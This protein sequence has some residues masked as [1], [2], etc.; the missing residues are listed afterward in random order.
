MG[1]SKPVRRKYTKNYRRT[2]RVGKVSLSFVT[3][4]LF[5][6]TTILFLFQSNKIAVKGYE[7]SELEKK[8]TELS[9][10]NEKLI[11]E[12]AKLQSVNIAQESINKLKMVPVNQINYVKE[13]TGVA[14][15]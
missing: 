4:L 12:S 15:R 8:V 11:I 6:V 14:L 3:I 1:R 7:I 2:F 5:F 10:I 13:K 9:E